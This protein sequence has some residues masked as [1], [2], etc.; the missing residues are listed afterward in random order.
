MREHMPQRIRNQTLLQLL[1]VVVRLG[2]SDVSS[3]LFVEACRESGL[4]VNE[5]HFLHFETLFDYGFLNYVVDEA[6]VTKSTQPFD[7]QRLLDK[8]WDRQFSLTHSG[9][10]FLNRYGH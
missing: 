3:R 6:D 2:S 7:I 8:S 9:L 1:R 10:E 5:V 4:T